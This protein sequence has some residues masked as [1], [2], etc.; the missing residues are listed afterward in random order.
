MFGTKSSPPSEPTASPERVVPVYTVHT[1]PQA[2]EVLCVVYSGKVNNNSPLTVL[3]QL[4]RAG[5]AVPECDAVIGM[6][7]TH[8]FSAGA[9]NVYGTAIRYL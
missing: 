7:I 2:Y 1:L 5:G 9:V 6:M 4:G 8:G 3:Q